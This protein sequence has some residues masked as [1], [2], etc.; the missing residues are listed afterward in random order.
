MHWP[1]TWIHRHPP[2]VPDSP[3]VISIFCTLSMLTGSLY[4][5]FSLHGKGTSPGSVF[6]TMVFMLSAPAS[7]AAA[8]DTRTVLLRLRH[9]LR[10]M[11]AAVVESWNTASNNPGWGKA[12]IVAKAK[13]AEEHMRTKKGQAPRTQRS[14]SGEHTHNADAPA[15]SPAQWFRGQGKARGGTCDIP[16]VW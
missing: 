4:G 10:S 16:Q 12:Y 15:A 11:A 6:C 5:S 13:I 1:K 9:G 3:S 8:A 7:V 2:S 14:S